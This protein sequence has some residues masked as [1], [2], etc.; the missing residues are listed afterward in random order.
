METLSILTGKRVT[1]ETLQTLRRASSPGSAFRAVDCKSFAPRSSAAIESAEPAMLNACIRQRANRN[2]LGLLWQ[3]EGA[4]WLEP[5]FRRDQL[6][7]ASR[8]LLAR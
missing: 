3:I 7:L 5:P 6:A 4:G 8:I 2:D 1:V